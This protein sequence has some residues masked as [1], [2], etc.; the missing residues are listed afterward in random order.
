MRLLWRAQIFLI[1]SSKVSPSLFYN[2]FLYRKPLTIVEQMSKDL[3]NPKK[4]LT[5]SFKNIKSEVA[6]FAE[7]T[8]RHR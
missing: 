1:K 4:A 6:K 5:E 8:K 3:E 7:E 2:F